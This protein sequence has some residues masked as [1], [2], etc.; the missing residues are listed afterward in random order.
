MT[1]RQDF[2]ARVVP[3]GT[4]GPWPCSAVAVVALSGT[5]GP[6]D[7]PA[8]CRQVRDLLT[9]SGPGLVVC[10][11]SG[12]AGA[13]LAVVDALARLQLTLRRLGHPVQ[14]WRVPRELLELFVLAGLEQV[15]AEAAAD[16]PVAAAG[17]LVA[18]APA[19]PSATAGA[20]DPPAAGAAGPCG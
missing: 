2:A 9:G 8:L 4:A 14:F 13:G 6:A 1:A 20:T 11:L 17:P 7:V 16:P 15:L 18:A 10:D 5:I 12:L 3:P 19:D